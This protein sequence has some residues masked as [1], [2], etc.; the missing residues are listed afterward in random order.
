MTVTMLVVKGSFNVCEKRVINANS[1]ISELSLQ[2]AL[3]SHTIK[4]CCSIIDLGLKET[5]STLFI[6][7]FISWLN[8]GDSI[9]TTSC[10]HYFKVQ[11]ID[12]IL[13]KR[14]KLSYD[15]PKKTTENVVAT[16]K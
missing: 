1:N 9:T 2:G 13:G 12:L 16:R 7:S 6:N 4:A 5:Q 14:I 3:P 10:R 8:L 15:I 11:A